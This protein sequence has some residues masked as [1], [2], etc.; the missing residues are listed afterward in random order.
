[1]EQVLT[2]K[3]RHDVP[4]FQLFVILKAKKA[5]WP[6][7]LVVK[8]GTVVGV[9]EVN[10]AASK[11]TD[12]H[13]MALVEIVIHH[14]FANERY[15]EEALIAVFDYA[16]LSKAELEHGTHTTGLQLDEIVLDTESQN[17]NFVS[18]MTSLG[19]GK[20]QKQSPRENKDSPQVKYLIW[21][22]EK[23]FWEAKRGSVQMGWMPSHQ[24]K[25]PPGGTTSVKL[26]QAPEHHNSHPS[27]SQSGHQ[28][29]N[30]PGHTT[31]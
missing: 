9:V 13:R 22:V 16:F 12:H 1:L 26:H 28:T 10:M 11:N 21:T 29:E 17:L 5:Y 14:L 27:G 8:E 15:G 30:Q 4:I 2:P 24:R 31:K 7:K 23:A 19:L 3:W 18:R 20:L 6:Q 25:L